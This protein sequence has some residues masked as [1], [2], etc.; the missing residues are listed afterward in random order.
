MGLINPVIGDI[1]EHWHWVK[2]GVEEILATQPQ[3]SYKP[4]DVY[5]EC[6]YGESTLWV[7]EEGF[8]V[9]RSYTDPYSG[10]KILFVWIAWA[11]EQGGK[12]VARYLDFVAEVAKSTEHSILEVRTPLDPMKPY[13]TSLG[14]EIEAVIYKKEIQ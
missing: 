13:L 4:E 6:L 3:L 14:F 7:A 8:V 1:R 2:P 10:K 11:K 12:N 9:A 5:A